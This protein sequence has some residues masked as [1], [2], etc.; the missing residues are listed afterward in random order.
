[1]LAGDIGTAIDKART[2]ELIGDLRIPVYDPNLVWIR[3]T[4]ATKEIVKF[5]CDELQ[6]G[7]DPRHAFLRAIYSRGVALCTLPANWIGRWIKE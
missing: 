4:E 6:S 1:M 5:W 7:A 3:R 2:L